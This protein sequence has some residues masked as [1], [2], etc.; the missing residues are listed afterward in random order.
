[1]DTLLDERSP[2]TDLFNTFCVKYL[3]SNSK[4]QL[5]GKMKFYTFFSLIGVIFQLSC[6]IKIRPELQRNIL[7]FGYSINYKYEGMLVHSF[8]RFYVVTKFMLPMIGYIQFPRLNYNHTFAYM[9]KEYGSNTDSRKY[10]TELRTYCNKIKHFVSYYSKLMDSY[11][12]STYNILQNEIRLLLPQVS[13]QKCGIITTLVSSFI[14]L[15]YKGISSFL[16]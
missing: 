13:R 9:K 10:L 8:D 11:N 12:K 6:C 2:S 15:A 3:I 7:N 1:M 16:Q 5:Q 4:L 14:D